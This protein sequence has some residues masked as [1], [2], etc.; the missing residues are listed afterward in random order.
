MILRMHNLYQWQE[1]VLEGLKK[2]QLHIISCG[3]RTGKSRY[4]MAHMEA[5]FG[6]SWGDWKQIWVWPW[7][8][9]RSSISGKRIWGNISVRHSRVMYGS[10]GTIAKEYA[11]TKETFVK[12]L[13][14]GG[15]GW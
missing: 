12:N 9:Q 13:K 5:V 2:G 8:S 3:R 14:D 1:D 7:R 11:T 10:D 15:Q 4:M 6:G